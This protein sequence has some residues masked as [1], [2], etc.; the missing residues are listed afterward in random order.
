M[1]YDYGYGNLEDKLIDLLRSGTPD[2]DAAEELIRQG[3][4]INMRKVTAQHF[5]I[6]CERPPV[7]WK[8]RNPWCA[9][10]KLEV[11]DRCTFFC[12]L[13]FYQSSC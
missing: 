1:A 3:A 13:F 6:C 2:F 10:C 5:L 7:I 11:I 9:E 12:F 8:S 4:D